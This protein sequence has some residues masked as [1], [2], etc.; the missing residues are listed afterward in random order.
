M[1]PRRTLAQP[2]LAASS[3]SLR[4]SDWLTSVA[5]DVPNAMH[6]VNVSIMIWMMFVV[7]APLTASTV[8]SSSTFTIF[9]KS[10][11]PNIMTIVASAAGDRELHHVPREAA[12]D[13]RPADRVEVVRGAAK[14]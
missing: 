13:V 11:K 6:D 12:R 2:Y 14:T 3:G 7:A 4:P 1:S 5:V 8:P 10:A 9:V